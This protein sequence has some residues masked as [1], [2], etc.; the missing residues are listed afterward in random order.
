MM[1]HPRFS[2]LRVPLLPEA[3][4]WGR[5]LPVFIGLV[6]LLTMPTLQPYVGTGTD[7][8]WSIALNMATARHLRF[9]KD[10]VF[11]FGPLGFLASPGLSVPKLG[12]MAMLVRFGFSLLLGW[13]VSR[14]LLRVVWWPVA[15]AVTWFLQWA[16]VGGSSGGAETV[17]IP[18]LMLIFGLLDALAI[19][20]H[21][22]PWWVLV[23]CGWAVA[24]STLTKFDTGLLCGLVIGG[25]LLAEGFLLRRRPV[26]VGRS[27]AIVGGSLAISI[28][29]WW[30]VLG[31]RVGDLGSWMSSSWQV[32]RG[33]ESA[34]VADAQ[35]SV[36]PHQS[37]IAI[38]LIVALTLLCAALA[39]DL[40]VSLVVWVLS[41]CAFAA[42]AKQSFT[43]YDDGHLQRLYVSAALTLVTAVSLLGRAS[44]SAA[45]TAATTMAP[46]TPTAT[47]TT[48]MATRRRIARSLGT[49]GALAGTL[50]FGRIGAN[51]VHAPGPD[52]MSWRAV[53]RLAVSA[54]N[55]EAIV[56]RQRSLLPPQLEM[57]PSVRAAL[58]GSTVHI[59]P[60]ETSVAWVFPELKWKPLPVF[61]SYSAYTPQ[62]DN[63]NAASID[64]PGGPGIVLFRAGLR[65]DHRMARFESPAAQFAFICNFRPKVL[66]PDGWQVFERRPDGSGC[67]AT[68]TH[69]ASVSARLGHAV[70]LPA[71]PDD[72]IVVASFRGLDRSLTER[73][74]DT[75]LRAPKYWF[76]LAKPDPGEPAH[77][78]VAGNAGQPHV[79]SVPACLRGLW[80]TYDTRTF[81]GFDLRRTEWPNGITG[82][83]VTENVGANSGTPY[84]VTLTAY[85]YK[86]PA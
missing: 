15:A 2:L 51:L 84:T 57:T 78:F 17:L 13:M 82:R 34:M 85:P 67:G 76:V 79:M 10:I 26:D 80:G 42:Y 22:V 37:A 19:R 71:L 35:L 8:S 12:V 41:M 59:E 53:A 52:T 66:T 40:R 63:L 64:S 5:A 29:L 20:K 32:F 46:T 24:T 54:K 49:V 18:V 69:V 70:T 16:V 44:G 11:T 33:Y 21:P 65:V 3:S 60:S 81:D 4:R 55:R 9:G 58:V 43:R 7:P 74:H 31:Q 1:S 45:S 6:G 27:A 72:A 56:T 38:A 50:I 28:V 68:A 14:S 30:V 77:R 36:S 47:K 83:Q 39:S 86:C 75:V 73:L 62:L 25:F 23:G 48:T 61:Q